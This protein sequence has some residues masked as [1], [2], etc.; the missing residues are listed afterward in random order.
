[1]PPKRAPIY[2]TRPS[3]PPAEAYRRLLAGV[4]ER[5]WLTN[6]GPLQRQ[7]EEALR[8]RADWNATNFV[9]NGTVALQL[10]IRSF[11]LRGSV[12]TTPYS[13]VATTNAL[14]W[15]HLQPVFADIEPEGFG[16]DPDRVAAAIR[17][18]TSAILAVHTYGLPNQHDALR[19]LADRH[20]IPLLYD[21]AHCFGVRWRGQPLVNYGDA[22][23]VS[24]HATKVFHTVE[25]G[26]VVTRHA[27]RHEGVRQLR[28]F[29]HTYDEYELAG[30]NGKNSE[31][32]AAM[33]LT[34]LDHIDAWI[35]RR[36][37]ISSWYDDLLA[38]TPLRRVQPSSGRPD[39]NYN[40]S[41]YPVV[42]PDHAARERTVQHLQAHRIFPRRYFDQPLNRLSYLPAEARTPCPVAEALCARVLCLP[43]YPDLAETDVQRIG[44]LIK[45]SFDACVSV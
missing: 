16:L 44:T 33:G 39:L 6:D 15:E 26:A 32:H 7:L 23:T 4:W 45:K 5:R 8:T 17:P 20:G 41:Y 22:A 31:L 36:R 21:A 14:L 38:D 9:T 42:F 3:M 28:S 11:G 1:M 40:Y 29:G 27:D 35:E 18:D 10:M 12:V 19:A 30:I 2:V 37:V 13:Y 34:N 25:G 24:F 43:L